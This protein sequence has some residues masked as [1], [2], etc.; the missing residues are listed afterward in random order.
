MF[1]VGPNDDKKEGTGGNVDTAMSPIIEICSLN[2]P[3]ATTS[4]EHTKTFPFSM[5][6]NSLS[7]LQR[8]AESHARS[9]NGSSG[10]PRFPFSQQSINL[11]YLSPEDLGFADPNANENNDAPRQTIVVPN[12][13]HR[14][15]HQLA[16]QQNGNRNNQRT[17]QSGGKTRH[18]RNRARSNNNGPQQFTLADDHPLRQILANVNSNS[19]ESSKRVSGTQQFSD[20]IS[21]GFPSHLIHEMP[22]D[23]G[24]AES[25]YLDSTEHDRDV[26]ITKIIISP[27]QLQQKAL[28]GLANGR[29][30][31]PF[32][33]SMPTSS[34]VVTP[35]V[36]TND[37]SLER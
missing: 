2:V 10:Q 20:S 4:Y 25:D 30:F 31:L 36:S 27:A 9:S 29:G 14:H 16:S 26:F 37:D 33:S 1:T 6:L 21:K 8:V 3:E 32:A 35:T 12:H 5:N 11:R 17:E 22:A 7:H 28:S 23:E 18:Q 19:K 24:R 13:R 34:S 15:H